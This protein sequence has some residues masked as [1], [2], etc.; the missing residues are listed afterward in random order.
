MHKARMH[1][2]AHT[3]ETHWHQHIGFWSRETSLRDMNILDSERNLDHGCPEATSSGEQWIRPV[4][5]NHLICLNPKGE[6][7]QAKRRRQGMQGTEQ[8]TR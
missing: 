7:G 4:L 5:V 8:A 3:Q 6:E 1:V 2:N